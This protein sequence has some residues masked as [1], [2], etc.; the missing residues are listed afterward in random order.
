MNNR[1]DI[2]SLTFEEFSE[3]LKKEFGKGDYHARA[4]YRAIFKNGRRTFD[5]LEELKKSGDFSKQFADSLSF[6]PM[7]IDSELQDEVT[8]F[9]SK[10]GDGSLIES[11]IIPMND[12]STLCISSQVGCRMG[13]SFCK[14][15]DMGF[16]RNLTTAE[17]IGQVMIAHHHYGADIRNIVFMGMGE[18][19]D[20][21]DA[22]IQSLKILT[23][24]HGFDIPYKR[25]TVSTSGLA[26]GI[27]ELI[28][29]DMT[30]VCLAISLNGA[31]DQLRRT[32][33]P[34]TNKYSLAD[35]KDALKSYPLDKKGVFFVEYVLLKGV[36]DSDEDV[37]RIVAFCDGLA[38]VVNLIPYNG[39]NFT[40]PGDDE[41]DQ[42]RLKLVGHKLF[43]RVRTARGDDIAAACGQLA[44]ERSN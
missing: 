24:Q 43:V 31:E 28:R 41:V 35:L 21:L 12:Y 27:R 40:R 10:L 44:A 5:D 13:C 9:V 19:L 6:P 42:F 38:V 23:G 15:G 26:E 39:E 18:P 16:T 32:I 8:K 37:Q 20:N 2:L 14:T 30:K 36:N 25:I 22:V 33:M 11:V 1:I 4:L 34:I 3:L 29:R 17:I 7:E